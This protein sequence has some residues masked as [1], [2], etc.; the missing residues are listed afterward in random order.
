[1]NEKSKSSHSPTNCK[2][3]SIDTWPLAVIKHPDKSSSKK[4]FIVAYSLTVQQSLMG[5]QEKAEVSGHM[6]LSLTQGQRM[7]MFVLCSLSAF[8]CIQGTITGNGTTLSG[9]LLPSI[10]PCKTTPC[11][12]HLQCET[13]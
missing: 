4:E 1:M 13:S 9:C 5:S 7:V 12:T 11:R 3:L 10:S 2:C 8:Y 6:T